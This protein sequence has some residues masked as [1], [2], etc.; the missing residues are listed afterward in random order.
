[1]PHL[2]TSHNLHLIDIWHDIRLNNGCCRCRCHLNLLLK[3]GNHRCPLLKLEVLLL[4]GV[5]EVYDRVSARPHWGD[6]TWLSTLGPSLKEELYHHGEGHSHT[7]AVWARVTWRCGALHKQPYTGAARW[8]SWR[9]CAT[10]RM[11]IEHTRPLQPHLRRSED[12]WGQIWPQGAAATWGPPN[13][14]PEWAW[15]SSQWCQHGDFHT[16]KW[17][18]L[19]PSARWCHLAWRWWQ[20]LSMALSG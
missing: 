3:R 8:W 20:M 16:R 9:W 10:G 15:L 4:I 1:M 14:E 13:S 6:S 2:D 17:G 12:P 11:G 18:R 19:V 7:L 5:L